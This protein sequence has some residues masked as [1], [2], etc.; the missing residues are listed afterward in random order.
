MRNPMVK[1]GLCILIFFIFLRAG[2]AQGPVPVILSENCDT[3]EIDIYIK[4]SKLLIEPKN[5]SAFYYLNRAVQQSYHC[6][7]ND[8]IVR[9]LIE[10]A[11]WHY[12]HDIDQSIHYAHLA[13]QEYASRHKAIPK[14]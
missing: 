12:G 11:A 14:N 8:R 5:D 3:A 9:S 7:F 4:K 10:L 6:N 1:F 2:F 13:L